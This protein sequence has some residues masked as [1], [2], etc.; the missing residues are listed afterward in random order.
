MV[1]PM[2]AP[3]AVAIDALSES[4]VELSGRQ[5]RVHDVGNRPPALAGALLEQP[6]GI[7]VPPIAVMWVEKATWYGIAGVVMQRRFL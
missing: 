7:V 2:Y 5:A 6:D 4:A 1:L 3:I